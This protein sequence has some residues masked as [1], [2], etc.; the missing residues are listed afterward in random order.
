MQYD[1]QDHIVFFPQTFWKKRN[2]DQLFTKPQSLDW[3]KLKAFADNKINATKKLKFAL[4]RLENNVEKRENAGYQHFLLF[5]QCF[6]KASFPGLLKAGIVWERVKTVRVL[7]FETVF[8]DPDLK[9][10]NVIS[11]HTDLLVVFV[12]NATLTAKVISWL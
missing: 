8:D 12:Y 5:P 10:F 2:Y 6:Q 7:L 4:G 11:P 1:I 9:R 3:S